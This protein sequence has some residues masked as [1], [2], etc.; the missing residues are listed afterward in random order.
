MHFKELGIDNR[1]LK[2]LKH[3]DFKHATDIQQKAIPVSIA[4]KDL[5]ASSKT[6]SG[7]T[8]AFLLDNYNVYSMEWDPKYLFRKQI[9]IGSGV[10]GVHLSLYEYLHPNL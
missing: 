7:K 2:N 1:L 3:F 4:E 9:R 6:G 5:M 8:L 10:N